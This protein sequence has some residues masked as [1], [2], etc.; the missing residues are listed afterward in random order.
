MANTRQADLAPSARHSRARI[1]CLL[2]SALMCGMTM[3]GAQLSLPLPYV[4]LTLQTFFVMLSGMILGPVYGPLSQ[5]AYVI[6]GLSGLPVFS[7]GG[8]LAY[9]FKPTF[10]YLL[11]YPA[12]SAVIGRFLYGARRE[13]GVKEVATSRLIMAGILGLMA[14]FIPG[15]FV[16]YVNLNFLA[17]SP[18]SWQA[19]LWSGFLIFIPGDA[20]KLTGAI[21]VYRMLQRLA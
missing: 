17:A 12:A 9:I 1:R 14:I 10:G 18:I 8:G 5:A 15:V 16:L 13:C 20:L 19:A 11:G 21:A 7:E 2:L 6:L 4:K 3:I